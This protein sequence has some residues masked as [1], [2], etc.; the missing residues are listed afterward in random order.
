MQNAPIG[1]IQDEKLCTG[2]AVCMNVCPTHSIE[3]RPDGEG[4]LRPFV[5]EKT[6]V[7]CEI[8]KARCPINCSDVHSVRSNRVYAMQNKDVSVRLSSSSGGI[9]PLLADQVLSVGGAIVGAAFNDRLEV[10]HIICETKEETRS[11]YGSKY[12]QSDIGGVYPEIKT[13][14]EQGRYVL[15]SGTPC[16]VAGLASYLGR[17]H[18]NLLLVD[19][20]CHGVPSPAVWSEY[21]RDIIGNRLV[22]KINFRDK[23]SGWKNYSLR[24]ECEEGEDY[25]SPVTENRYLQGFI[26]NLYLRPSCYDC[27]FKQDNVRS[28][29]TIGDFWGVEKEFPEMSDQM[30]TSIV[31]THTAKAERFLDTLKQSASCAEVDYERVIAGNPSYKHSAPSSPFRSLFFEIRKKRGLRAALTVCLSEKPVYLMQRHLYRRYKEWQE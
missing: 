16:Q 11:L 21:S 14:L 17:E 23:S 28:D 1:I 12:V 24:I 6:C 5:I 4:F 30:G 22:R 3:M 19:F 8:C 27:R 29:I 13:M 9:F 18:E 15:F 26:K 20:V 25:V 31:I 7:R 2:C 10:M